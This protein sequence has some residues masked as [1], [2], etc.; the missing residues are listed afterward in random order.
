MR[1]EISRK[2]DLATRSL[3]AL[4]TAGTSRKGAQLAEDLDASPGFLAQALT[5][6]VAAGWVRSVPGPTGG[7]ALV[8]SVDDISVL[9][10]IEAVEG[11][12]DTAR[13]VLEGR[14]CAAADTTACALHVPWSRARATLLAELAATS[15]ADVATTTDRRVDA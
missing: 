4:A 9:Q 1:L 6:L 5:P 2:A 8:A 14:A 11:P 7:Y 3:G 10:V 13:C 12:T 15:L